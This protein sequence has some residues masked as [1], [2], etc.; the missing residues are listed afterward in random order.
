LGNAITTSQIALPEAGCDQVYAPDGHPASVTNMSRTP[1]ASDNV[2]GDDGG[3]RQH[4]A[5][6]GT[7]GA[8]LVAALTVPVA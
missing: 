1:L 5:M 7:V 3:V 4:A 2:L 6:S 8:G